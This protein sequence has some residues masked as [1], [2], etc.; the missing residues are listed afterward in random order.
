MSHP[1][2]RETGL[3]DIVLQNEI[4]NST[5]PMYIQNKVGLDLSLTIVAQA[6]LSL[7]K[8]HCND[9]CHDATHP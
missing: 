7:Q 4:V 9:T 5:C 8:G 1:L 6:S 2:Q 3:D